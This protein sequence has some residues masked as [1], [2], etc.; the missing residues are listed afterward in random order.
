MSTSDKLHE[1][2]APIARNDW[3]AKEVVEVLSLLGTTR[4]GLSE[5]EV[6][7]RQQ[8]YGANQFTESVRESFVSKITNQF[9]SPIAIVLVI[10]FFLTIALGHL[11]DAAVIAAALLIA[12]LVGV[13]QEGK[14]SQAFATLAQSQ[15]KL[16]T[17]IRAGKKHQI[18]AAE[19]VPGDIV[20]LLDG[21]QVPADVRILTAKKLSINEATLTGEWLA[22]KKQVAPTIVGVPFAERVSMAWM[23]TFVSE[24]YGLGVVVATGD[25]TAVGQLA[26]DVQSVED[27]M[28]PLQREMAGVSRL[29]LIVI[30]VLV[31]I[32]F[33]AGLVRQVAFEE[34]L[35]T[36]VAIAVASVP[37]GLPA[38]VTIVLAV[39]MEALLKRGG[40]V[41]SLLAAET[42]GSTTYVLTD[43]TGTLT[44]AKMAVAGLIH[45]ESTYTGA[46][47]RWQDDM[48]A[49]D[50]FDTALAATNAYIDEV[51]HE[52]KT[53][54]RGDPVERAILESAH[55]IGIMLDGDTS[56]GRRMDYLA[57]TSENR[58]AAGLTPYGATRRLCINGAPE[59]LLE[60]ATRIRTSNGEVALTD[61]YRAHILSE[62]AAATK[63]GKRLVAVG[64]KTVHDNDIPDVVDGLIDDLVFVGVIVFADPVRP[65]VADA[66][67]GVQRAGARICLI[68]GDN[69]ETGLA[70]ARQVG[71]AH[72]D[73][74]ALTG[75]DLEK[76]SDEEVLDVLQNVSVFARVLPRQKMRLAQILQAEGEIVAMTGDGIND[77][78]ALRTANIGVA[79]G[80][81][82]EVAKEASDLVL[83]NDT[84]ATIYSAIEEGRRIIANLR[85][86]VGYLLSTSL[87]EVVLI[88]TALGVG[89]PPPLTAVQILWSNI[90]EEGLMSVAYAFEKGE[91]GAMKRKPQDIHKDGILSR[92]M[93]GFIGFVI[94]VL[95][96]LTVALYFIMR[97]QNLSTEEMRSV[98]F[99]A[100]ASDS[101]FIALSFRSLGTPLWRISWR[102]NPFFYISFCVS[103][104]LL[105]FALTI[106]FMQNLLDYQPVTYGQFVLAVS[107]SLLALIT[108]EV[109]KWIFFERR[110]KHI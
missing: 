54:V 45:A 48:V 67:A 5:D 33:V 99:L 46:A 104:V 39:G 83:V 81:G 73:S 12:V 15:V 53:E 61:D 62:I 31:A 86:I 91:P 106:P 9:K 3:H 23:G 10:A 77:A 63:E 44:Q 19:L 1:S 21:M 27:P 97:G 35:L 36:A 14:A 41:R 70:I 87:S 109:A 60:K 79:I 90:I 29:L 51:P 7:K 49:R 55:S 40:L 65:G 37:E 18:E 17:V 57:F 28:T 75:L 66:I 88:G 2:P 50:L 47:T 95:S 11:V 13:I 26:Q 80:S 84:F 34:M 58:F 107:F 8:Q 103:A 89:A 93:L 69:P 52:H 94:F 110:G 4:S 6:E 24:G 64:Y 42:L 38:A 25:A 82:T 20:E 96:S 101:L 85:K 32:I 98:M 92:Q 56:R 30:S 43:K 68:T 71:I 22:V 105:V 102:D 74:I 108:V 100:I 72:A 16:A 59:F 76:M 78:P